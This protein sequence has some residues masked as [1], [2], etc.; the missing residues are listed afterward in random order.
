MSQ[1]IYKADVSTHRDQ[2]RCTEEALELYRKA[3][4]LR[5][6]NRDGAI[7]PNNC[8]DKTT[9]VLQEFIRAAEK[10]VHIYC[11]HLNATIYGDLHSDFREALARDVD[12]RVVC[13]PGEVDSTELATMLEEGDHLRV[14][15]EEAPISHFAVMDGIRYRI[16]TDHNSKEALVC[17]YAGE[18]DQRQRVKMLETAHEI[19]WDMAT[20]A[21]N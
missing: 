19:L 1:E 8:P 17:A 3:V 6:E 21:D 4:R 20:E 9:V 10:S 13:S 2:H 16:E 7:F 5:I 14:L 11:G 18:P 12:V 15:D